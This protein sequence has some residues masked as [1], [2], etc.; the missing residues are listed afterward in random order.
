MVGKKAQTTAQPSI[1]P[2]GNLDKN[3]QEYLERVKHIQK[4][5]NETGHRHRLQQ[6]MQNR[7]HYKA[8]ASRIVLKTKVAQQ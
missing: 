7:K 8:E 3:T 6:E 1:E 4:Q 5:N 2:T